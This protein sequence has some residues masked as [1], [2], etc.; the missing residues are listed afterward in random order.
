MS[1]TDEN[2]LTTK[3][4]IRERIKTLFN[5]ELLSDVLLIVRKSPESCCEDSNHGLAGAIKKGKMEIPA[6]KF[7]LAISS[8]V[9]FELFYG[10]IPETSKSVEFHDCE[11][12]VLL[13]VL[14]YIYSDEANLS[15]SN[16]IK[17]LHLAKHYKLPSLADMC[18][19]YLR[20]NVT[21]TNVIR[22][23]KEA[24]KYQL[25]SVVGGRCWEVIDKY[26][27]RVLRSDEFVTVDKVVLEK[28][29]DRNSL[30]VSEVAL[31][32][33]V[34]SWA[35]EQCQIQGFVQTGNVKRELLGDKIVR[36]IRYPVMRQSE[37]VKVVLDSNILNPKEC[38]ELI[39]HYSS[40]SPSS[41]EFPDKMRV[42]WQQ[43]SLCRFGSVVEYGWVYSPGKVDSIFLTVDKPIILHGIRLCGYQNENYSLHLRIK[44]T[45]SSSDIVSLK[46]HFRS[47]KLLYKSSHYW[48]FE[49]LFDLPVV[50]ENGIRYSVDAYISGAFSWRGQSGVSSLQCSG[51]CFKFE[52]SEQSNNGTSVKKGQFPEFLFC[53]Q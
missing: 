13:E 41:L 23:L 43:E 14:R 42:G 51:V 31:F 1:F 52:N 4:N 44:D 39:R 40:V 7:V 25:E 50:I 45:S 38:Y 12:E 15:E 33:A 2:W 22:I 47:Q 49:V 36:K 46:R 9:F 17:V 27:E 6:H 26:T 35:N 37:F 53:K 5:N 16:A 48:G 30:S 11:Y 32:E 34:N 10:Q 18:I 28:L 24:K 29:V 21:A 3:Q 20:K 8:P 19:G